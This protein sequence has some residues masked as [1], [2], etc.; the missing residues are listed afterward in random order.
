MESHKLQLVDVSHCLAF[1]FLVIDLS[2]KP[3]RFL[4]RF[5]LHFAGCALGY[6]L[7]SPCGPCVF[8]MLAVG[9][10]DMGR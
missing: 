3:N 4:V 10:R 9:Y 1:V 6:V 7:G 5:C 2:K 8:Y